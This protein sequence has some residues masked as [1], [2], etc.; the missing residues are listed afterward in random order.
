MNDL[1]IENRPNYPNNKL[2]F[3]IDSLTKNIFIRWLNLN[4]N[5]DGVHDVNVQFE[6]SHRDE[7]SERE[8]FN[9]NIKY[10]K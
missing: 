6:D 9:K 3:S 2:T 8:F 5:M 10:F 7:F 1:I 4:F